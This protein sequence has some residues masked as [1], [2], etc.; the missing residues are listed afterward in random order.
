MSYML[1]GYKVVHVDCTC[2]AAEHAVRFSIDTDPYGD[3]DQTIDPELT[4]DFQLRHFKNFWQ[5]L[6]AAFGY[7]F[8]K[9]DASWD[10]VALDRTDVDKLQEVVREYYYYHDK[11]KKEKLG[12]CPNCDNKGGVSSC[13]ECGK[14]AACGQ[15]NEHSMDCQLVKSAGIFGFL[16]MVG[17]QDVQNPPV[18]DTMNPGSGK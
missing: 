17:K 9:R 1:K 12:I 10:C 13:S 4:M 18:S 6:K 16:D 11:Y 2:G 14:C 7:V 8:L 15:I 5:R 3:G